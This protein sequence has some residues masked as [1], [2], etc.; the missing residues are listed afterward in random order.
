MILFGYPRFVLLANREKPITYPLVLKH[1]ELKKIVK[2]I[3]YMA[4]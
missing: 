3:S 2:L 1:V 4:F